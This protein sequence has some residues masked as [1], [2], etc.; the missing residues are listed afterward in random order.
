M[1]NQKDIQ[2]F[3]DFF[4]NHGW[5]LKWEEVRP[6]REAKCMDVG[7]ID[8][9]QVSRYFCESLSGASQLQ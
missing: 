8:L 5:Q 1:D 3:R 9:H 2:L 6:V 7:D 4:D